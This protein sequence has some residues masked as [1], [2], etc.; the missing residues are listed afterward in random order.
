MGRSNGCEAERKRADA[1][2]RRAKF[3]KDGNSQKDANAKSMSLVCTL[4]KQAFMG[5]Q[6]KMALLHQESKHE[7]VSFETCFPGTPKPWG[8]SSQSLCFCQCTR[9]RSSRSFFATSFL[10]SCRARSQCPWKPGSSSGAFPRTFSL[11]HTPLSLRAPQLRG[12]FFVFFLLNIVHKGV[13]RGQS[14]RIKSGKEYKSYTSHLYQFYLF[15]VLLLDLACTWYQN[16][17][18]CLVRTQYKWYGIKDPSDSF[19]YGFLT[20]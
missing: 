9:L 15:F 16:I 13:G 5:T 17:V 1:E 20:E 4:C 7:K 6:P 3:N 8:Y 19:K 18:I 12:A 2:K 10:G 11:T 14:K